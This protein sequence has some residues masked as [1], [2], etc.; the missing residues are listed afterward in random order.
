[1]LGE[2]G[3]HLGLRN[4]ATA[5]KFH[6][7]ADRLFVTAVVDTVDDLHVRVDFTVLLWDCAV[8]HRDN[9]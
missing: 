9:W 4:E 5:D 7:L 1:M 6:L 3:Y 2:T 8:S